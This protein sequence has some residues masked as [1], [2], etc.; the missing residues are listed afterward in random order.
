MSKPNFN[1]A[2]RFAALLCSFTCGT[3]AENLYLRSG[4]A[5]SES[6]SDWNNAWSSIAKIQ[7]GAGSGKV[8]VGDTLWVAA[9]S[10]GKLDLTVVGTNEGQ[11]FIRRAD[12]NLAGSAGALGW[13]SSFDDGILMELGRG[14]SDRNNFSN[15]ICK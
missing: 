12:K 8:S 14:K 4:A 13:Q 9:G 2:V 10:Y 15:S 5:G 7:W 3:N 11:I 6:G 1:I